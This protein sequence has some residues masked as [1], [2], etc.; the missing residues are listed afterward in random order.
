MSSTSIP[1]FNS[2]EG[3]AQDMTTG[4]DDQTGLSLSNEICLPRHLNSYTLDM[5][6]TSNS[7][8]TKVEV[9]TF[10]SK[11]ELLSPNEQTGSVTS[12][13]QPKLA[14]ARSRSQHFIG[15]AKQVKTEFVFADSV[16]EISVDL[17]GDW[18]DWVAIPMHRE[19]KNLW[20]V[21][22]SLN[23]G[24]HEFCFLVDGTALVTSSRH[25]SNKS[26][27]LPG[28]KEL[29]WRNIY[30]PRSVAIHPVPSTPVAVLMEFLSGVGVISVHG[31]S[32]GPSSLQGS[33][34]FP[35]VPS[36]TPS[37]ELGNE[38]LKAKDLV[39]HLRIPILLLYVM[40]LYFSLIGL[41]IIS[42][43]PGNE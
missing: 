32:Y 37:A 2:E 22:V 5:S 18:N 30:G 3:E 28:L 34:S 21:K 29:N 1:F 41:A 36:I 35:S 40:L 10:Q 7:M 27:L 19:T 31:N 6:T 13:I 16:A 43:L 42:G 24:Y 20:S 25:K 14:L 12:N 33:L 26:T 8:Q 4:K 17:I 11:K 39:M 23:R 38:T 9:Q 15:K